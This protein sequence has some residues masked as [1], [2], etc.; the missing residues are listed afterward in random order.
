MDERAKSIIFMGTPEFSLPSLDAVH[1]EFGIKAVVTVPDKPK[2]RG[3][4]MQPPAVKKRA[5]ELGL[6]VVQPESLKDPDFLNELAEFEPDIMVVI[7]FRILPPQVYEIAKI[8]A[9]NIHG[10]LLPKYRGAAPINWAII[11]GENETGLTSFLLRKKVDTGAM[12]LQQP[13]GIPE[14]STAGDLHDLMMP[15]AANLSVDTCRLL[16]EGNFKT[17]EQDDSLATPAPKIFPEQCQINWAQH[18][19]DLRNFIH[20]VSPVPGA[21]TLWDAKRTKILRVEFTA[22]GRGTPGEFFIE[23]NKML[24]HCQKGLL[25]VIELQAQGKR[26]MHVNDFLRG[27]RGPAHGILGE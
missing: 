23:D 15:V 21:W 13:L 4:K 25:S 11:N 27:Y 1:N 10:S 19:R 24:V 6:P 17:M 9:F 2:G 12:L 14:G 3:K 18:A 16:I 22:C 20:G 5:I 26:A 7:A 8:G